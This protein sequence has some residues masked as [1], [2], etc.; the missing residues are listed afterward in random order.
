[1]DGF[2]DYYQ[3]LGVEPSAGSDELRH[4]F[5]KRVREIHPDVAANKS[6]A[7]EDFLRLKEAY[8]V[9]K[10]PTQ[11]LAFD[12]RRKARQANATPPGPVSP[13]PPTQDF[14]LERARREVKE[15]R[16]KAAQR[17]LVALLSQDPEHEQG[18]WLM[19][20]VFRL[21]GNKERRLLLLQTAVEY[22][23]RSRDLRIALNDALNDATER[24]V[25]IVDRNQKR[26][27]ARRVFLWGGLLLAAGLLIRGAWQPSP[28]I[29]LL[30]VFVP[31]VSGALLK[32]A[33]WACLVVAIT[34]AASGVIGSLDEE[35]LYQDLCSRVMSG[36]RVRKDP[37]LGLVMP[38]MALLHYLMA[39]ALLVAISFSRGFLSRSLL[40]AFLIPLGLAGFMALAE[41]AQM[42]T[43]L[44]WCPGW[45]L[46]I[47]FAGWFMGDL[48]RP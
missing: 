18:L 9:L 47:Y 46:A 35:L 39:A 3:I 16:L 7:H 48:F 20:E 36:G 32:G 4:A 45:L 24:P 5:R 6:D 17:D 11:R 43:I 34:L 29:S 40:T 1:M 21:A 12:A 31:A 19:S 10:N 42:R 28:P 13:P 23:P 8:S 38:P 26:K 22:H 27:N 33:F 30:E 44:F 14:L 2:E 25:I 15:G 41:P 37:P